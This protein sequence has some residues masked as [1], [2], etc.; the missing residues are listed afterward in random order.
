MP[1][2]TPV[3]VS[4]GADVAGVMLAVD[5]CGAAPGVWCYGS[6]WEDKT[7]FLSHRECQKLPPLWVAFK[8]FLALI[9]IGNKIC[10]LAAQLNLCY[11]FVSI[12]FDSPAY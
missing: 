6:L 4:K 11:S 9:I 7:S 10:T 2:T 5:V 3:S 8:E 12:D 1:W